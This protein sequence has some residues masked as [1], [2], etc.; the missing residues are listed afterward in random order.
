MSERIPEIEKDISE[1]QAELHLWKGLLGHPAWAM[2]EKLVR[3]QID[4]RRMEICMVPLQSSAGVFTQEFTK[5]EASGAQ[6]ALTMVYAAKEAAEM[7]VTRLNVQLDQEKD[8]VASETSA[9]AASR[10][11]D[12]HFSAE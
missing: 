4:A 9:G 12:E 5:G 1:K 11:D 10:V 7:D 3:L 6:L 2:Y 8:N